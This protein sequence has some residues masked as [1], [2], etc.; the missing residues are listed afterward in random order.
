MMVTGDVDEHTPYGTAIA[1]ATA[2]RRSVAPGALMSD[3][4]GSGGY[5]DESYDDEDLG[6]GSYRDESYYV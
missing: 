4:G 5:R 1:T 2:G 6:S 3:Q